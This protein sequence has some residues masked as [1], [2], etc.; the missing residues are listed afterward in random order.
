MEATTLPSYADYKT[1]I[2]TLVNYGEL[3][4]EQ[5]VILLLAFKATLEEK[6]VH[7]NY[8]MSMT[9]LNWKRI[10]LVVNGLVCRKAIRKIEKKYYMV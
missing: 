7:I 2:D 9:G 6:P 10:N 5:G 1:R 8:L 4:T 3:T